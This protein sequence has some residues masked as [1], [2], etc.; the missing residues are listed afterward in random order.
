MVK[1]DK[2]KE[3]VFQYKCR[4]CGKVYDGVCC[5]ENI[6]F[7]IF[8]GVLLDINF[9]QNLGMKPH[10]TEYHLCNRKTE[11]HG[12]GDLIGYITRETG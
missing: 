12:V 11:K 2:M 1:G 7:N 5:G 8:I 10:M 9:P 6:V 4:M 3:A